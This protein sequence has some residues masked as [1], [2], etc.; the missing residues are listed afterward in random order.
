MKYVKKQKPVTAVRWDGDNMD[1]ICH[2]FGS[3][4]V[5]I[6]VE[7]QTAT[8]RVKSHDDVL[9]IESEH[10]IMIVREDEHLYWAVE[11]PDFEADYEPAP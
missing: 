11:V 5:A 4:D 8:L 9:L 2:F 10:P 1:D 6:E 3:D 7:L